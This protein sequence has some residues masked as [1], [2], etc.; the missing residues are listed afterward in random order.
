[1]IQNL[2]LQ[3]FMCYFVLLVLEGPIAQPLLFFLCY[4]REQL[5]SLHLRLILVH[6]QAFSGLDSNSETPVD[7]IFS[8]TLFYMEDGYCI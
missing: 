8:F 7:Q 3:S 1:M 5:W 6:I 4:E 2:I